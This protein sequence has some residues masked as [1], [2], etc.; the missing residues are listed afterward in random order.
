[1]GSDGEPRYLGG[2]NEMISDT[3]GSGHSLVRLSAPRHARARRR[4]ANANAKLG[5][6]C[7][8]RQ[9]GHDE[10]VSTAVVVVVRHRV[11]RPRC[12]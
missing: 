4:W 6:W 12:K 2:L 3:R 5:H 9:M 10:R 8:I 11:L 1:M 7:R